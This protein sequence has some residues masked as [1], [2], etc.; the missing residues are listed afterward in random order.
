MWRVP[1][2]TCKLE[3]FLAER[4]GLPRTAK[5]WR[6]AIENLQAPMGHGSWLPS[7]KNTG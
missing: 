7:H 5:W 1:L 4:N 2:R 6:E 3:R